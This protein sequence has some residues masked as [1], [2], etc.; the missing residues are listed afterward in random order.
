MSSSAG[1][2]VMKD[3]S[4]KIISWTSPGPSFWLVRAANP[5]W[6]GCDRARCF[7]TRSRRKQ[8]VLVG[9]AVSRGL[10]GQ[11]GLGERAIRSIKTNGKILTHASGRHV[12][13]NTDWVII[14]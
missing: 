5:S 9:L 7:S 1:F 8:E 3:E 14:H 10:I 13:V 12:G 2:S 4:G 11:T 6:G